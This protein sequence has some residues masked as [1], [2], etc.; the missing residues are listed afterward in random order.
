MRKLSLA[1]FAYSFAVLVM[2][3]FHPAYAGHIA[4]LLS[5]VIAPVA[6]NP[7]SSPI[8]ENIKSV[9]FGCKKPS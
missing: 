3:Y 2:H 5:I 8:T 6:T 1:T 7:N 9:V 4:A